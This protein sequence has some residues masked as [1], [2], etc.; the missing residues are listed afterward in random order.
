MC[1]Q[2]LLAFLYFLFSEIACFIVVYSNLVFL[3]FSRLKIC[4]F[5]T[6]YYPKFLNFGF[7][8]SKISVFEVL[9]TTKNLPHFSTQK[10]H[11]LY[12]FY[13]NHLFCTCFN[14]KIA[15]FV[16]H[17]L[18][19]TYP[20]KQTYS[21]FLSH[22]GYLF[23][24]KRKHWFWVSITLCFANILFSLLLLLNARI[25]FAHY[26]WKLLGVN[27]II[28]VSFDMVAQF[29]LLLALIFFPLYI[30][31]HLYVCEI[32]VLEMKIDFRD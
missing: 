20:F 21:S 19:N 17:K 15:F 29:I 23:H 13:S 28:F 3:D 26:Y 10:D 1:L 8:L 16:P 5:L 7:F 30:A 25:R 6:F 2:Y 27:V 4:A 9:F 18:A 11:I 31:V 12:L 24:A 14:S 22:F 32:N